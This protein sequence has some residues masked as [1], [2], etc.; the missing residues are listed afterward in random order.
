MHL[1]FEAHSVYERQC[2]SFAF[3][4]FSLFLFFREVLRSYR[5]DLFWRNFLISDTSEEGGWTKLGRN[6]RKTAED[7]E[8]ALKWLVSETQEAKRASRDGLIRHSCSCQ[9]GRATTGVWTAGWRQRR[10]NLT[11]QLWTSRQLACPQLASLAPR[12]P[13]GLHSNKKKRDVGPPYVYI[14]LLE[15]ARSD[16]WS[17]DVILRPFNHDTNTGW[18]VRQSWTVERWKIQSEMK[19]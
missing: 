17:V 12:Q 19:Q 9:A 11:I 14:A 1:Y 5:L 10:R 7:V 4:R 18:Q 8:T 16:M 15:N 3:K 13:T 2:S 6:K